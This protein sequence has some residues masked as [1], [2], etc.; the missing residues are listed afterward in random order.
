MVQSGKEKMDF[1]LS[2]V[3]TLILRLLFNF[4]KSASLIRTFVRIHV[5]NEI[6]TD[7]TI[8]LKNIIRNKS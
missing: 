8:L 2:G 7:I 1:H 4:D 3:R 6:N 5:A